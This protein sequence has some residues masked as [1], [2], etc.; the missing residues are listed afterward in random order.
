MP[1]LAH[2][3]DI[4][5]TA[6]IATAVTNEPANPVPDTTRSSS[7]PLES[8]IGL[9]PGR[10]FRLA[11][12]RCT[13]CAAIPQALWYFADETIAA[14][15]A[16]QPV[17]GFTPAVTLRQDLEGWARTHTAEDSIDEPPLVWIGAPE[18]LRGARL[19]AGG[20]FIDAAGQRHAFALVPKLPL[21][22][23]YYD[24][25]SAAFL[26]SRLL[27]VRG[28]ASDETFIA[29]T[30]WP[31]DF[32]LESD[33]V[34]QTVEV[35]PRALRALVRA[36]PRGGAQSPF[37]ASLL[38]ERSPGRA[39]QCENAP[40]LAVLLNG[41]QGDDDEAHGGH[42][43]LVTG[44]VGPGGA[45][46]DWL[47]NNFYSL[48]LVSEKGI[49]ASM[50]PLDNYLGDLNSGQ[51]WYRPSYLLVAV[52]R[53]ETAASRIQGAL[54]RTYNHFYRHQL[55]YR[56]ATMNCAGVSVDVLRALG[57]RVPS[58]GATSWIAATLSV[59]YFALRKRNLRTARDAFDYLTEDQTRLLPA[60]AFEEIG[61]DLLRMATGATRPEPTPLESTLSQD[62]DAIFFVRV[63]QLP[64]SRAWGD[65]P[66]VSAREYRVRVPSD[67]AKR[68][69]IP[70]PERPF[71]EHLREPD[72]PA[73]PRRRSDIAVAM[74]AALSVV[75]IPW[76][77][78][79]WWRGRTAA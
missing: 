20:R 47:A 61:A 33:G 53:H 75:G 1:R 73:P 27:S 37:A 24:D 64:S 55:V 43:A 66:V 5:R 34:L 4:A 11:T 70:V 71:P 7:S 8:W 57:W 12:G 63:P 14:P 29:R 42:F 56:H 67:P 31:E 51:A 46:G 16:G 44:R 13:D 6:T 23:S 3:V 18:V 26:A 30:I 40:V 54:E 9:F 36:E 48:D 74:W 69:I 2:L 68:Q 78:W 19:S 28:H 22:R 79:R 35:S 32:R 15:R 41:A 25:S 62:L 21:N 72:V 10:D 49:L 45:M 59:P 60:A 50:L 58:R 77:V 76:L 17:A 65:Y 39:R 52:L 38:W